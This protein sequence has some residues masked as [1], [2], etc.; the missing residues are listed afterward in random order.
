MFS[1]LTSKVIGFKD[2][3]AIKGQ[4]RLIEAQISSALLTRIVNA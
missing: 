2:T 3:M 4:I 1:F